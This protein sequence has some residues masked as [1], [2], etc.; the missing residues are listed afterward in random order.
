M[1]KHPDKEIKNKFKKL[2]KVINKLR[3]DIIGIVK[4]ILKGK[5]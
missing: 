3:T 4:D 2:A 1:M 5:Y